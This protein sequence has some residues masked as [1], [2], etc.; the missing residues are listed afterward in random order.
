[1]QP[2]Q[3]SAV[4][5]RSWLGRTGLEFTLHFHGKRDG[6]RVSVIR[7]LD[8]DELKICAIAG[9]GRT[10]TFHKFEDTTVTL[11]PGRE[12]DW[13]KQALELAR[14]MAERHFTK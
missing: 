4:T 1:M 3:V 2:K 12:G 7:W 9:D 13:Q 14:Q 8:T 5:E 6:E 11:N 10:T